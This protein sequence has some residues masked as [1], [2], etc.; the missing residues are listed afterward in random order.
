MSLVRANAAEWG[1]D[2]K[3]IGML[4]FSAGG[5]LTA[6]VSL[7]ADRSYDTVDAAD[8]ESSIPNFGVLIYPGG[9]VDKDNKLKPEFK[10][11][12]QSPPMCFV[13]A[14]DDRVAVENSIEL[15]RGL[16]LA[17]VPAELHLYA[18]GGHGF[19]IN[20]VP[21]PCASW[22]DRVA[23]WLKVRGSLAAGK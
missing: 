5:H 6:C 16:K 2:P 8:K 21:H 17:K 15:Y 22:P 13:H 14:T 1:I 18:S 10:I 20:S 7:F 4:G 12:P 11:T 19:G 3:R 23:D 9:V